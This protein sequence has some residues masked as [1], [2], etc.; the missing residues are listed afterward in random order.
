MGRNGLINFTD[1]NN[2]QII[3]YSADNTINE[4]IITETLW[5]WQIQKLPNYQTG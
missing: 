2:D 3:Q 4:L 1:K 5:Y